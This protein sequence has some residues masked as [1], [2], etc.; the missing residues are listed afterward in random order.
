MRLTKTGQ[1]VLIFSTL[2]MTAC[3]NTSSTSG[4]S[5]TP[6]DFQT[7]YPNFYSVFSSTLDLD[8]LPDYENQIRPAYITLDNSGS[9]EIENE[10]ALLG[11]ILFY[12][13]NLSSSNTVSCSSCHQQAHAFSDTDDVS[14]GVNGNTG[15][16]SMRL[17]NTRFAREVKFFWDE[18]AASLEAQT[19][20][21]IQDH[22]EMGFSGTNGDGDLDDLITKLEGISYYPELFDYA[23]G[24]SEITEAKIQLALA[25]FIRSIESFDSKYDT[26]RA[27]AANDQQN[28]SNFTADENTGKSLFLSPP[29]AGG[30][31][32][33]GC[34]T[35]PNFDIDPNSLSNGVIG[36]FGSMA[37]DFTVTRSPT[38]RDLFKAN[39]VNNGSFMHDASFSTIEE[40]LDH[41][42]NGITN[43][44]N[45]DNR[46]LPGGNPQNLGLTSTEMD[47]IIS[48]LKTLSG[49]DVYVNEKWSTPF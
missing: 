42:N 7:M 40:V 43:T 17:I 37:T 26:G 25:Q 28:F 19:T 9:N 3:N 27:L 35:P 13:V 38:L 24:S 39:G 29:Q 22:N 30:A 49:S 11:R 45:L 48:F 12:D 14:I 10:S 20:Q 41:Y 21:P 46:L 44:T 6:V 8:N 23:F 31:G 1:L 32:C 47:Q 2:F 36:V 5:S 4:D 33:A 15:R 16:H 18:R 34:H